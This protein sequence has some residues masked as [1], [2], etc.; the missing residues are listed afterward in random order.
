M[1]QSQLFGTLYMV[2]TLRLKVWKSISQ[3]VISMTVGQITSR[4]QDV[5]GR[6]IQ[7]LP[8]YFSTYLR[9]NLLQ[10]Q[11]L[12]VVFLGVEDTSIKV[13]TDR[14]QDIIQNYY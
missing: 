5:I 4:L 7:F 14:P 11:R 8:S 13:D 1:K 6:I 9:N 3:N 12:F 10:N 2:K